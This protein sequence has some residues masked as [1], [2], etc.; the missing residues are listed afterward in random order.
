MVQQDLKDVLSLLFCLWSN[1]GLPNDQRVTSLV[2]SHLAIWI[3]IQYGL[4]L[5]Q[6]LKAPNQ[7]FQFLLKGHNSP[8]MTISLQTSIA[9]IL[10]AF[11][12][13]A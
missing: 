7:F 9:M 10:E 2:Q 4:D 11:P 5:T 3:Q 13:Y 1:Q 8:I 12:I 6:P